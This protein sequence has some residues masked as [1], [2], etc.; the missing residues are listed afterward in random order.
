MNWPFIGGAIIYGL[1]SA[2]WQTGSSIYILDAQPSQ[3]GWVKI[4][5]AAAVAF[6]GGIFLYTR[7][8]SGAWQAGPGGK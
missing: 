7:N 6:V 3:W 1:L 4:G 5:S 2:L 8:P